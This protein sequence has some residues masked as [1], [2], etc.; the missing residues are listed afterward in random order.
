M[1]KVL[2][3]IVGFVLGNVLLGLAGAF[4]WSYV[5]ERSVAQVGAIL[6]TAFWAGVF[7]TRQAAG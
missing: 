1:N 3:I 5:Y 6:V 4:D 7:T 2:Q